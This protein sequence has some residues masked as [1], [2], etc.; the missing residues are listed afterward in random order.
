[1]ATWQTLNASDL[2]LVPQLLAVL[3]QIEPVLTGLRTAAEI[4]S[5]GLSALS[6]ILDAIEDPTA[7]VRA[8]IDAL[9]RALVENRA[10]VLIVKPQFRTGGRGLDGFCSTLEAA[11]SDPGD[12][13]RPRFAAGDESTGVIF[14]VGAPSFAE[15]GV[16]AELFARLF[17]NDWQELIDLARALPGTFYPQRRVLGTG[18]V[19]ALTEQDPHL[20]FIDSGTIVQGQSR[21]LLNGHRVTFVT[22]RNRGLGTR[23]TQHVPGTG[24]LTL[25][26]ALPAEVRV[27]DTYITHHVRSSQPPDWHSRRV[28]DVFPPLAAV[29]DLLARLRDSIGP[30]TRALGVISRI[31]DILE[32]KVALLNAIAAQVQSLINLLQALGEVTNVS[33]LP[34]A[35][36]ALGNFGFLRAVRDAA[37]PP[38]LADN[39]VVLGVV[40]YGGTG[41]ASPLGSILGPVF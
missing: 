19:S 11:L 15:L 10:G 37:N 29:T 9:I 4:A 26:P 5:T 16:L 27:G 8:A 33:M 14:L 25:S 20:E 39:S 28:I 2:P 7:I 30:Q 6:N 34:V 17:G 31:V 13:N 23:I 38:P 32:R 1:M 35:P 24:T 41:L 22:G 3:E 40:V 18:I 12:L 21:P 36:Q